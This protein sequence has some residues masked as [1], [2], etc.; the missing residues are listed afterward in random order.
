MGSKPAAADRVR[1][2]AKFI[3]ETP[4]EIHFDFQ[5]IG[6][7]WLPDDVH[8]LMGETWTLAKLLH[9]R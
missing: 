8:P 4:Q 3:D 7:K 1:V 9:C 2:I 5:K 6:G